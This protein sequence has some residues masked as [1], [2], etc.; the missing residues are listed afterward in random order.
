MATDARMVNETFLDR[1]AN[2]GQEKVAIDA[3]NDFTRLKMREDGILRRIMPPQEPG[4]LD[5]AVNSDK[6]LK[7]IDMEVDSPAAVSLPFNSQPSNIQIKG[8][9]YPVFFER[10]QS[11]RFTKDIDELRTYEM[12]IRQIL[13]DNAI[14]DMLAQEDT[15]FINAVNAVL[16]AA[17]TNVPWTGVP[18]WV[19]IPGGLSRINWMEA[20]KVMPRT[21][22]RLESHTA[23][24]NL[25]T[26]KE[27]QKWD[28][29]EAGGDLS[30]DLLVKGF[31]LQELDNTKLV[32]TIK[33][34]LVADDTVY[35]FADPKF[36]GKNFIL[37]DTTMAIK[38]D[39]SMLDFCAY[40]TVGAAIANAAGVA[41][42]DFST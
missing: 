19:T 29:L 35:Y 23:L 21:F 25:I 39:M 36:I 32:V 17:D 27:I 4:R 42:V 38:R 24:L 7:I 5:R 12:D 40:E 22:A 26:V 10:I 1:L 8:R 14:K 6:P 30:Q 33:R 37:N 18:Q 28:R 15:A 11:P 13:S 9:K 3:V 31:T 41:R 2:P 34:N 20:K 16:V